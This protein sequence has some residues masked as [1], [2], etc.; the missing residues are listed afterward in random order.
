M[1]RTAQAQCCGA[2]SRRSTGPADL[3]KAG[4]LFQQ[5]SSRQFP[6]TPNT[7]TPDKNHESL[8]RL[9][10]AIRALEQA[11]FALDAPLGKVQYSDKNGSRIPI[12]GGGSYEGISNI[13]SFSANSPTLE[14]Y[15]SPERIKGSR[16]LTKE[17]YLVNY[18]TSFIMALEFTDKGPRAQAF[19]TYSQSGDPSSPL[20]YDQTQL[21]SEKK[22]R[23]ILFTDAEIKSDP[24]LKT[25][26]I[27]NTK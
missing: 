11:G 3:Q 22:W 27:K 20:F 5:V 10:R 17:G 18:G 26:K 23:R 1:I 16:F 21:F 4:V 9:A 25:S 7:L 24:N 12:H 13:V 8:L 6:F 15:A 14:P 19:L 2:N